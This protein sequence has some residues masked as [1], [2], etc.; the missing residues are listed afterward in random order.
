MLAVMCGCINLNELQEK[1]VE[2]DRLNARLQSPGEQSKAI[3]TL[4]AKVARLESM[5]EGG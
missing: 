3:E 1:P 5:L 2:I 4:S